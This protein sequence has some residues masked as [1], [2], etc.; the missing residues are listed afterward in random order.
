ML[1]VY[2]NIDQYRSILVMA[3]LVLSQRRRLALKCRWEHSPMMWRARVKGRNLK[4][5]AKF[6]SYCASSHFS[7]KR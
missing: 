6:Y 4:L 2:I 5:E 1:T 3:S 7:F